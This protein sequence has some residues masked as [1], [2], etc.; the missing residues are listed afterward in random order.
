MIYEYALEPEL[1]ATW[2][3][4]HNFRYFLRE[5][6]RSKGRLVSR[7]P[8]TWFKKVWDAYDGAGEMDKKRLEELLIRMKDIMVKRKNCSWDDHV[9]GWLE[10]ALNEHDRYPFRAILARNNPDN[11]PQIICEDALANSPCQSWDLPHGITVNRNA[12]E[13]ADAIKGILSLCRWVKF[14]DPYISSGRLGYKRSLQDFLTIINKNRP[15]G[16]PEAVEIHTGGDGA[17]SDYLKETFKKCIPSG[18]SVTL[19]Q[20]KE[21]PG[22]QKL[23]NRYILTDLGGVSFHHGLDAGV[24]GETDD[25]TRLDREQYLIRNKQYDTATSAFDQA[26]EPIMII[27]T[28]GG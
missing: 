12:P 11:L 23:H 3:S 16:P 28:L 19:F 5:F 21:R 18:L 13:M 25:I 20:W 27:G 6:D 8:K 26:A 10:N 24:D 15:I 4:A 22:G 9:D 7:Y 14:I 17:T 2:G 1:V